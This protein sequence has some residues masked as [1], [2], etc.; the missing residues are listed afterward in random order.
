MSINRN[1]CS[2]FITLC[3]LFLVALSALGDDRSI[4]P[5]KSNDGAK[6]SKDGT[7]LLFCAKEFKSFTI[8]SSV[9]KIGRG[10]FKGCRA[11]ESVTIP[12]SVTE[13]GESAFFNC[14][15]LA[16]IT[17]PPSVKKIGESAFA[18]CGSLASITIPPSVKKIGD[19]A[20]FGCD[21][22]SSITIPS[23]VTKIGEGAF[24]A[25]PE[26]T[27]IAKRGST[28]WKYAKKNKIPVQEPEKQ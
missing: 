28:A 5:Q 26:L 13:I 27:I 20:F 21:S 19:G 14:G 24:E 10:A 25:C 7:M 17:I 1:C 3:G 12:S 4:T 11:L 15:S 8:P 16:S 18:R 23:S 2:R 6:Y 9:T 22:L